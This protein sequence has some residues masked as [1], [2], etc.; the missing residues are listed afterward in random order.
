M[1][2]L[3]RARQASLIVKEV[4]D[5]TLIYDMETDQAHCLNDTAARI[6]KRCDG[7]TSVSQIAEGLGTEGRTSVDENVVWLALDQLEKFKLL[8]QRIEKPA[9]F[10]TGISRRQAVRAFGMG[11]LALPMITSIIAPTASQAQSVIPIGGCCVNPSD[12]GCQTCCESPR[13]GDPACTEYPASPQKSTKQ[14]YPQI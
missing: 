9:A 12:C 13:E 3:P 5:E 10:Q 6:W 11:A 1:K 14:C 8:E 7:Q 4:D 2:A